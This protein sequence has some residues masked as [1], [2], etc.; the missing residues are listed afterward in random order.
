MSTT[1]T[2]ADLTTWTPSQV[3]T[4]LGDLYADLYK[5]LDERAFYA[6]CL[7]DTVKGLAEKEAG[8]LRYS[9]YTPE[10]VSRAQA[11]IDACDAQADDLRARTLPYE[12]EFTRRGGWTRFFLVKNNGGHVHSSMG[13]ST[14]NHNGRSTRFGW[15]PAL[16]GQSEPEAVAAHGA[17]LCTTCY[18]SAPVEWTDGRRN[19]RCPGSGTADYDRAKARTGYYSGNGGP[20]THCGGWQTITRTGVLRAHKP[21]TS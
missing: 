12:A 6:K 11:K 9:Y 10:H 17:I 7:D 8:D 15:L 2:P 21:K 19:D 5:V 3:D 14:C 16:S 13:C 4:V 20:C 18:P 1:A